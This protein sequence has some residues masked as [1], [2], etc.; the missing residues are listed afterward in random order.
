M[1]CQ[2]K[3]KKAYGYGQEGELVQLTFCEACRHEVSLRTISPGAWRCLHWLG[4]GQ[5]CVI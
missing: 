2:L 4:G 5:S 1:E 3:K